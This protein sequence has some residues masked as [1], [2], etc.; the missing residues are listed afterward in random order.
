MATTI[1]LEK[2]YLT[3]SLPEGVDEDSF[4]IIRDIYIPNTANH[5]IL[6]L[7][8]R[9]EKYEI[10][11]KSPDI[12]GDSSKQ[13]EHTITLTKEEFDA[14]T[15]C[16]SKEVIKR[17]YTATLDGKEAEIDV[18]LEKLS[19]LILVDFEFKTE[20]EKDSFVAPKF[21]YAEVTQE[22]VIAGGYL[23]GKS[24]EDIQPALEKYGYK[25]VGE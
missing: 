4:M 20:V 24:I 6:R 12:E 2:T 13:S 15:N 7:R 22:E 19:G 25:K 9:G 23:A 14:M 1:E 10:T 21:C 16:S 11:K 3:D 5:P 18:F 8:Q 17:R